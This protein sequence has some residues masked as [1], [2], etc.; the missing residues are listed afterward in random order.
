MAGRNV[1]NPL[2]QYNVFQQV[3][4]THVL[5]DVMSHISMLIKIKSEALDFVTY[6]HNIWMTFISLLISLRIKHS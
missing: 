5:G 1:S 2:L 6:R 4:V 3:V